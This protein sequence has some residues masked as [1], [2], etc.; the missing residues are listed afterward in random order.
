MRLSR[1]LEASW[2]F[3]INYLR[4]ITIEEHIVD[5]EFPNTTNFGEG[6]GKSQLNGGWFNNGAEG[7]KEI[8]TLF[9]AK[10]LATN[11]AL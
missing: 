1:I 7:F 6:N 2:L 3:H 10:S 9:L 5:V 4:L 8:N 11:R